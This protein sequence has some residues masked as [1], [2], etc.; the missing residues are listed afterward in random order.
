MKKRF[1]VLAVA[2]SMTMASHVL[3]QTDA[4]TQKEKHMIEAYDTLNYI[5][6]DKAKSETDSFKKKSKVIYDNYLLK[7][8]IPYGLGVRETFDHFHDPKFSEADTQGFFIFIHGGYWQGEVKDSYA[9]VGEKL[10]EQNI[11][12]ILIEYDLTKE[13]TVDGKTIPRV[14]MTALVNEVGRALDAVQK[15]LQTNA[16]SE[17]PV[18]LAGHS[19]GGHLA[20]VWKDHP[21]VNKAVFP[22]SG[23]FDLAPIAPTKK[24]GTALQLNANEIIN[25]SPV[26]NIHTAN[27]ASLPLYLYYG[28]NEQ[29]ELKEQSQHYSARLQDCHHKVSMKEIPGVNHFEILNAL[30]ADPDSDLLRR[31]AK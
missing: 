18:Y 31:I 24:I 11:D 17:K 29:P 26:N 8:N 9:F 25:L 12:L 16:A 3:A 30:F 7:K 27:A 14:G 2:I 13:N 10:L 23:L 6:L 1:P 21:V 19:A 4:P 20:A 28:G 22:I 15:Y 5:G